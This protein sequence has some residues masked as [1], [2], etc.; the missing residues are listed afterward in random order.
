[1]IAPTYNIATVSVMDLFFSSTRSFAHIDN[2]FRSAYGAQNTN[3]KMHVSLILMLS[4]PLWHINL[5]VDTAARGVIS[6]RCLTQ[7]VNICAIPRFFELLRIIRPMVFGIHIFTS[8]WPGQPCT[9]G[10]ATG[11]SAA[12]IL[13]RSFH[14][15]LPT[16]ASHGTP[17]QYLD[18]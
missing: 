18:I 2:L 1:M 3:N 10:N 5:L 9:P 8:F 14:P 6:K 4:P 11:L 12:G 7:W 16:L 13:L 17:R 15:P